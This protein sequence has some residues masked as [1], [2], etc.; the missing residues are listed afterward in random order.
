MLAVITARAVSIVTVPV[1]EIDNANGGTG[2]GAVS[3]P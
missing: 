1:G 2:C 3:Y